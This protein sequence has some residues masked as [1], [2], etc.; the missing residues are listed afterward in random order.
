MLFLPGKG[1]DGVF[2]D[3]SLG[4][5]GKDRPLKILEKMQ[6]YLQKDLHFLGTCVIV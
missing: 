2:D 1:K 3:G 5:W 4:E 6:E